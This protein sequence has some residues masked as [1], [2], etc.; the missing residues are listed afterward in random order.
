MKRKSPLS[1]LTNRNTLAGLLSL[2]V[3]T[4]YVANLG[5]RPA[6]LFGPKKPD[7]EQSPDAG[8]SAEKIATAVESRHYDENGVLSHYFKSARNEF[9]R[10]P[11]VQEVDGSEDLFDELDFSLA[12]IDRQRQFTVRATSPHFML[13]ENGELL[14]DISAKYAVG[15]TEDSRTEL[16]GEVRLLHTVQKSEMRTSRLM[17]NPVSRQMLTREAVTIEGPNY[18]TTARGLH[19]SLSDQR[20]QLLSDV[21]SLVQPR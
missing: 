19:G 7:S 3:V 15:N 17:L 1:L 21:K 2:A 20:W 9:Y 11:Q 8:S 6:Q 18:R 14:A 13:Y 5:W 12:D 4:F 10:N 16:I